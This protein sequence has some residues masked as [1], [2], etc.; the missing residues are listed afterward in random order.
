MNGLSRVSAHHGKLKKN[1]WLVLWGL[2]LMNSLAYANTTCPGLNI[3]AICVNGAWQVMIVP[4]GAHWVLMGESV[5]GKS[6]TNNEQADDVRWN[7]AFTSARLGI[8]GCNYGLFDNKLNQIGL[9]QIKST[10]Y[11]RTGSNWEQGSYPG[12]WTC[13]ESQE[14][15]LFR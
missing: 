9:I 10:Q 2:S 12:N 7:Y 3:N 15:C 11:T 13:R 6:C 1:V 8:A 14:T 4:N 5:N